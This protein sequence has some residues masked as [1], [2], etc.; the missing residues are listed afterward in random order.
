MTIQ[1]ARD[2]VELI[3]ETFMER[4]FFARHWEPRS[5]RLPRKCPLWYARFC[6]LPIGIPPTFKEFTLHQFTDGHNG[7]QPRNTG[8][9]PW[10]ES[11]RRHRKTIKRSMA[12]FITL[13]ILT[14]HS[15]SNSSYKIQL[16]HSHHHLHWPMQRRAF[17]RA[18]TIAAAN[19]A[20]FDAFDKSP[21]GKGDPE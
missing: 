12:V 13:S 15:N 18:V 6:E 16:W 4:I 9:R 11:F 3:E 17:P 21:A 20:V 14:R 7:P 2:F 1:Q 19:S 8:G 5:I 10:T